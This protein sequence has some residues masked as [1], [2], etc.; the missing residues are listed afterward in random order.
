VQMPEVDGFEV[1][2]RLEGEAVPHVV[3]VTA[4]DE[5]ALRAFDANAL[6]YLLKP[7]RDE[8]FAATVERARAAV[9]R[10]RGGDVNDSLQALLRHVRGDAPRHLVVRSPGRVRLVPWPEIDWVEAAGNY[11]LVHSGGESHL[12]RETMAELEDRLD[13]R[14][15]V[16]THRSAIVAV[17][18]IREV[19]L[20]SAG[21]GRVL[22]R[23]G[24]EIP[25]SRRF[26]KRFDVH[27]DG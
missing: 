11:V 18:R 22:L 26:R 21:D 2:R 3:F 7:F 4:Y 13:P 16:R 6:D 12:M 10:R 5:Y 14:L 15:F 9:E 23:D 24:A 25:L 17:D 8:R 1:I 20:S 19:R 27:L